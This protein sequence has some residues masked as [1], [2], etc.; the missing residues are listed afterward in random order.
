MICDE[1]EYHEAIRRLTE[2][3]QR[4]DEH[5]V[6]LKQSGLN[7]EELKRVMDPVESFHLQLRE[8]VESYERLH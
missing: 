6:R 1:S 8:E 2:Q 3:R 4:L 5:F 7:K